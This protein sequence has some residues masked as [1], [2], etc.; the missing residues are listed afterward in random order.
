LVVTFLLSAFWRRFTTKAALASLVGGMAAVVL[1]IFWPE[2]ITPFAHGVPMI[3]SSDGFFAGAKQYKYMRAFFGLG[4]STFLG[5]TV[6]LLTKHE[7]HEETEGLVCGTVPEAIRKYKGKPGD[8]MAKTKSSARIVPVSESLGLAGPRELPAMRISSALAEMLQ[9]T[10]G[11]L[12]YVTDSR[13]WLGGLYST[14][15]VVGEIFD[16]GDLQIQMESDIA[17]LVVTKRRDKLPVTI[18]K[19][20]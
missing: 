13:W 8:E 3:E 19:L 2:I 5:V 6:A 7:D 9:A 10:E 12:L 20:Y 4:V 18:E 15:G 14:H 16:G 1:S 17:E 11:D